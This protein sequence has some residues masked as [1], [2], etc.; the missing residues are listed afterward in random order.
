[1]NAYEYTLEHGVHCFRFVPYGTTGFI[2]FMEHVAQITEQT[3]DKLCMLIDLQHN[4]EEVNIF[5]ALSAVRMVERRAPHRP[6]VRV[7]VIEC[8]SLVLKSI[9]VVHALIGRRQ[10][11]FRVFLPHEVEAAMAWLCE[12]C[13]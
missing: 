7:A 13:G 6:P 12:E 8:D 2:D 3:P 9:R 10:D 11:R 1:L 4:E 5:E